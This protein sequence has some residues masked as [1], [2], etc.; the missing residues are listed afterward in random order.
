MWSGNF[1]KIAGIKGDHVLLTGAK[2]IPADD[3]D[4]TKEKYISALKLL[5]FTAYNDLIP[6]QE[7]TV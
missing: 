5:N 2:K 6:A 1:M 4:E 7:Y 3:A